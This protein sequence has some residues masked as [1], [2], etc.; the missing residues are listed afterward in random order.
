M[1]TYLLLL[2]VTN[3]NH[4]LLHV[5]HWSQI[6]QLDHLLTGLIFTLS[7]SVCIWSM[8]G[9]KRKASKTEGVYGDFTVTTVNRGVSLWPRVR[10]RCKGCFPVTSGMKP[11]QGVFPCDVGYEA[12]ARGVSLWRRVLNLVS[13]NWQYLDLPNAILWLSV[14]TQYRRVTDRHTGMLSLVHA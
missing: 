11:L 1:K 5:C 4:Y 6:W 7:V 10:S 9:N 8:G 2:P 13:K 3:T 12:V 14:L